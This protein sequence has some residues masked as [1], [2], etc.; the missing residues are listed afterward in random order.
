MTTLNK[1]LLKFIDLNSDDRSEIFHCWMKSGATL[2]CY[3]A[4]LKKWVKARD[5]EA[6]YKGVIYRTAQPKP[7]IDFFHLA[8]E[9]NFIAEDANGCAHAFTSRPRPLCGKWELESLGD[10]ILQISHFASYVPGTCD[11]RDSLVVRRGYI[12]PLTKG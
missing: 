8:P 5:D 12:D 9:Y 2:D 3:N 6:L 4:S 10:S 1:E 7:L 11:W